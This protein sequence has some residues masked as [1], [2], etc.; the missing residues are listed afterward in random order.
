MKKGVG[1]PASAGAQGK[2]PGG[3]ALS[4]SAS[5]EK[6]GLLTGAAK[7]LCCKEGKRRQAKQLQKRTTSLSGSMLRA[8]EQR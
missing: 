5:K 6:E 3:D 4:E 8:L 1:L 7:L 2:D